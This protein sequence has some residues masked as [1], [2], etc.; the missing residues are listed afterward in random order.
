MSYRFMS[1]SLAPMLSGISFPKITYRQDAS[2]KS[3]AN[4][5]G[6][7]RLFCANS[8][9]IVDDLRHAGAAFL[10]NRSGEPADIGCVAV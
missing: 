3:S 10:R 5:P 7:K 4:G 8:A 6:R 9:V 2:A 1:Q